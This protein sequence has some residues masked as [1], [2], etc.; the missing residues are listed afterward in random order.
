MEAFNI[1]EEIR[2][3]SVIELDVEEIDSYD[4]VNVLDYNCMNN[5]DIEEGS[6]WIL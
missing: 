2:D 4:F 3:A 1:N 5:L 6:K